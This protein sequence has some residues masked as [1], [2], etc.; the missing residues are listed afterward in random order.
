MEKINGFTLKNNLKF[1]NLTEKNKNL[2]QK[3]HRMDINLQK[4]FDLNVLQKNSFLNKTMN[5][6]L[7]NKCTALKI[8]KPQ[9]E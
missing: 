7:L 3:K 4:A 9:K 6:N 8:Q 5:I 1:N 2:L